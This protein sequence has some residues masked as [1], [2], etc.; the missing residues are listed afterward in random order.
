MHEKQL[1]DAAWFVTL[2]YRDQ[3]LPENGSLR[4]Q[5]FRRFVKALRR[6]YPAG[7]VRFFGCGEYGERSQRPH[8]HAVLYGPH[9]LDRHFLRSTSSGDV[10][11]SPALESYWPHGHSELGTVTAASTAYVAGYVRKK[12]SRRVNEDAYLRVDDHTGELVEIHQEFTRMSL[13]PAIGRRWIE[14]YWQDVYPRD[15]VVVGG[16][17]YKPPRYY[18]KWMDD[19]HPE[20]MMRVREKRIEEAEQKSAYQLTAG[21]KIHEARVSLFET[22]GTI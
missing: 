7:A 19:N 22:R 8:Y 6:D 9:F 17:Q 4:P 16:K 14:R 13:R 5:D 2:T 20:I 12:V 1:H 11:R 15:F 18:D 21:E 3:E 10:W